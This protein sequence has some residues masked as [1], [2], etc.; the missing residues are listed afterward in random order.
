MRLSGRLNMRHLELFVE[1]AQRKSVSRAAEALHLTQPAVSRTLREL[2]EL[3][4]RPLFEKH[5]RGIRLSPYGTI[6]LRHAGASLAAAREGLSALQSLDPDQGPPLRIGALPTVLATIVPRAVAAYRA[7]GPG[8]RLSVASGSNLVLLNDLREGRLDLVVG[9]LPAPENM[10]AVTFEPLYRER[11][12]VV[13]A[14]GHPLEGA[15]LLSAE[16]LA[17]YPVLLP[18]PG[19]I[20][21]PFVERLLMEQGLTPPADAIETV[22]PSFGW[23]FVKRSRA[24]WFIS[25]GVVAAQLETGEFAELPMDTGT[26]LG[27]VGL[28]TRLDKAPGASVTRFADILRRVATES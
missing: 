20:I 16:D 3:C 5:G 19:S 28:C 6:F 10:A 11:V 7:E 17:R 18:G 27:S 2:E 22:S 12:V 14:A 25:Q 13:V 24:V 21:R 4:G 1:V 26:T 8:A 15:R 9:R 23:A